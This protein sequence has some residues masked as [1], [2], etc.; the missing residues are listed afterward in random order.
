MMGFTRSVNG[1]ELHVQ[2]TPFA[3]STPTHGCPTTLLPSQNQNHAIIFC[4]GEAVQTIDCNQDGVVA[5]GL[6]LRNLLAKLLPEGVFGVVAC[7][8]R[9]GAVPCSPPWTCPPVLSGSA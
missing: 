8:N 5:E 6:K 9:G 1:V 2:P 7:V 3:R 4:S